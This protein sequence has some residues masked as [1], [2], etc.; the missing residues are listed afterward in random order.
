[1]SSFLLFDSFLP[2][3]DRHD[4]KHM[5]NNLYVTL[6]IFFFFDTKQQQ[7][8]NENISALRCH[9]NWPICPGQ[10]HLKAYRAHSMKRL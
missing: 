4:R 9:Q 1:M 7:R 5:L 2:G 8:F 3:S 10:T 6:I